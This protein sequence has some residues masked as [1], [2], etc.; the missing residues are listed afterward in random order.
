M[1]GGRKARGVVVRLGRNVDSSSSHIVFNYT[2]TAL[3]FKNSCN[4]TD[5]TRMA[6]VVVQLP[7]RWKHGS[8]ISPHLHWYQTTNGIN[9]YLSYRWYNIGVAQP[10]DWTQLPMSKQVVSWYPSSNAIQ[11][12]NECVDIDGTGKTFSSLIEFC[13]QRDGVNDF[14]NQDIV[15]AKSFDVHIEIDGF[16]SEL[17]YNKN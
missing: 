1:R 15:Y 9:W 12:I 11:Q 10:S 14:Y 16:G 3:Q 2:E 7:H 5:V 6:H 4:T 17:E 8:Q 13:I